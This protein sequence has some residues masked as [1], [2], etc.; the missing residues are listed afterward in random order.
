VV[1]RSPFEKIVRLGNCIDARYSIDAIF[2][3]FI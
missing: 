3:L 1:H 2:A